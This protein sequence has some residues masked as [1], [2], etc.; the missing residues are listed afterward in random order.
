MLNLAIELNSGAQMVMNPGSV[1]KQ[2][3]FIM[4]FYATYWKDKIFQRHLRVN[5][6]RIKKSAIKTRKT[7]I[8]AEISIQKICILFSDNL[9]TKYCRI[10]KELSN[11]V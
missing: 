8:S 7:R 2:K 6:V 3:L 11:F 1:L 9:E 4:S 5:P 10:K